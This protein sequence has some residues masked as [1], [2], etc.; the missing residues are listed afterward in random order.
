M[1]K[2]LLPVI[3]S[4]GNF[5]RRRSTWVRKH[6]AQGTCACNAD[7]VFVFG[8]QP[9][10]APAPIYGVSGTRAVSLIDRMWEASDKREFPVD[11]AY[12]DGR[13]CLRFW[14]DQAS[15]KSVITRQR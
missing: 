3:D 9:A 4:N 12:W 1:A 5:S 10:N 15:A 2:Q 14:A 7:G 6:E 8:A 11:T 13:G